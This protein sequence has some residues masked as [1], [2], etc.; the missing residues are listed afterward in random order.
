[1]HFTYDENHGEPAVLS[2]GDV[3]RRTPALEEVLKKYYSYFGDNEENQFFLV[4][5][6]ACDL[7]PREG[8]LCKA[9]YIELAAVRPVGVALQRELAGYAEAAFN[10][11]FFVAGSKR[12]AR[13]EQFVERLYNNNE[14]GFFFLRAEP[15]HGLPMDSCAFLHLTVPIKAEHYAACLDARI[16]SLTSLF[17]AKLGWLVGQLYARVGTDDWPHS[18]L[19]SVVVSACEEAGM[20]I[21]DKLLRAAATAVRQ[22][23]ADNPDVVLDPPQLTK[24]LSEI[25]SRKSQAMERLAAIMGN[26]QLVR[27]LQQAGS[28][29]QDDL[30]KL[31][32]QI[33]SD[34]RFSA[35]FT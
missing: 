28:M 29:N 16:L 1:M 25:P 35:F 27:R 8:G 32:R 19:R 17:Q 34:S 2:Q 6:Q 21:D 13:F 24:L 12:K 30:Q 9:K 4:I 22:W 7:V 11:P 26:S 20:W 14:Q 10:L 18:Q 5:T 31:L 15:A 23:Q 3:L 33:S